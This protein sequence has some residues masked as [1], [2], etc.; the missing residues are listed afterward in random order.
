M[1]G[2]P[3][4]SVV[5]LSVATLAAK[6]YSVDGLVVAVD[7]AARTML[8]SHRPIDGYMPAMMMPFRVA[9]GSELKG[10]YPGARIEFRLEV[11][12]DHAIARAVRKS[13]EPDGAIPPP[14]QML[15]VG[16]A[17]GIAGAVLGFVLLRKRVFRQA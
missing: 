7:P 14:A 3:F 13:G 17:V 8:V 6:T 12:R 16:A 10:L 5:V 1:R 2:S 9:D 15:S 4:V 11:A